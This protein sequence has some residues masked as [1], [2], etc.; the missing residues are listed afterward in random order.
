MNTIDMIEYIGDNYHNELFWTLQPS[1]RCPRLAL[2]PGERG[3]LD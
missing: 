2:E 1:V 3:E